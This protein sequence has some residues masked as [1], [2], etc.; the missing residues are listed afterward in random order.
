MTGSRVNI[1]VTWSRDEVLVGSFLVPCV[2]V[3]MCI[4]LL[5]R[6]FSRDGMYLR[7]ISRVFGWVEAHG[8]DSAASNLKNAAQRL[9]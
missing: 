1:V 9:G 5:V 8:M 4:G 7:I 3:S 6:C 2:Y